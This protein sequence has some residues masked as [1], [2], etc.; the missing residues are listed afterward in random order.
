ML[1]RYSDILARPGAF[2]MTST[3]FL[4][5]MPM[6]MIG[7]GEVLLV[8]SQTGSYALAGALSATGALA[9][10]V[11]GPMFGRL[12][13]RY[14]Q[15]RVLPLLV[16]GHVVGLLA[17]IVLVRAD[18]P[19]PVLF[20][21]VIVSGG[22]FP[23]LG[24]MVRARWA[25]L[26][27]GEPPALRTAFAFESVLDEAIY[28][29]GPPLATVLAVS[30]VDYGALAAVGVLL[31]VGTVLFVRLRGTEPPAGGVSTS[32]QGSALRFPG[33]LAVTIAFVF[34]GALFGA[35]E[36]VTVAFADEAGVRGWTGLLLGLY[37]FG[38][39]LSGIVLGAVHVSAR[40]HRQLFLTSGLL[41]LSTIAFPFVGSP[42]WLGVLCLLAGLAVSPVL[43]SGF[44]LIE[45]LVPNERMTEG[46]VWS[47]T[48]LGVGLA[49][50][51]ALAGIVIDAHGASVAYWICVASTALLFAVVAI[52]QPGLGRA[53]I[54]AHEDDELPRS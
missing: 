43:I 28:V 53:W 9:N 46:L 25:F 49:V 8:S 22:L 17:F 3:G 19:V 36:V 47:N 35:F 27:A 37:A 21:S 38:S 12:V 42:W 41:A 5:R 15:H 50:A 7:L 52:A 33:V 45:R 40:L 10:S 24:A 23:N 54:S 14:G 2:A 4:A 34:L 13:D 32:G 16:A 31:V 48:G 44:A 30:V 11:F 20:V 29:I 1:S 51:A 39:G 26:L 6:S 18:A